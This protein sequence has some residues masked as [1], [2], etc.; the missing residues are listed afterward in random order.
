MTN[1]EDMNRVAETAG[2][3]SVNG[4]LRD[5]TP[6]FNIAYVLGS[7]KFSEKFKERA[8]GRFIEIT[9]GDQYTAR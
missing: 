8:R 9:G 5:I 7:A 1:F 6:V 3:I 4:N 2:R